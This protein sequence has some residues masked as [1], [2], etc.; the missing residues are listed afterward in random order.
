MKK[1]MKI[2]CWEAAPKVAGQSFGSYWFNITST[3]HETQKMFIFEVPMMVSIK[4]M[5]FWDVKMFGRL[6]SLKCCHLD[7]KLNSSTCEKLIPW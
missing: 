5:A 2:W 7:T 3:L 4:F 1:C 6:V